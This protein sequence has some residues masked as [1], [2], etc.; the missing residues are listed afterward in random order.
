MKF[1]HIETAMN[2]LHFHALP[3]HKSGSRGH[4]R[5][6]LTLI[7]ECGVIVFSD[8]L[9][10]LNALAQRRWKDAFLTEDFISAV[11]LSV[12][13]HALLEKYLTPYKSMTAKALLVH[14]DADFMVLPRLEQLDSLDR[15]IARRMLAGELLTRPACLAPLPLAGVPGWWPDEEQSDAMFYRDLQ[16]FRPAPIDLVSPPVISL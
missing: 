16:V 14:V 12:S 15:V 11:Q 4:L 8:H 10:I 3:N 7:D 5:D 2:T 13:G 6:A 1:P 9:K